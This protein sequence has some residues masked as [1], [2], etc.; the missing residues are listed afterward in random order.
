M[1]GLT[2]FT[3]KE[4]MMTAFD[5]AM[6]E[7]LAHEGGDY[8]PKPGAADQNPTRKGITQNTFD[9][10]RTRLGLPTYSVFEMDDTDVYDIYRTYWDSA[11]CEELP[12][13]VALSCFDMS[14]NA[15]PSRAIKTFQQAAGFT[16]PDVDGVWGPKTRDAAYHARQD[17]VRWAHRIQTERMAF[18]THIADDL[19]NF[20]SWISR[21]TQFNKKFL[22]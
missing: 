9:S 22:S 6:Q 17:E 14:I 1:V 15:G 20:K 4:A 16:G 13:L 7:T 3:F 10:Y 21:L 18:Y 8:H 11:H 5:D 2:S 12:Y 19:N